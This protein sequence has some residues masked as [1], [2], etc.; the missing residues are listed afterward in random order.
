[1]PSVWEEMRHLQEVQSLQ[2]FSK[3]QSVHTVDDYTSEYSESTDEEFIRK[4]DSSSETST[5]KPVYCEMLVW[6]GQGYTSPVKLQIDCGATVNV[7]PRRHVPETVHVLETT[8][9]L[10]MLNKTA[11]KPLGECVLN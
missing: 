11:V 10:S 5:T 1:V 8:V 7:I 4:V 9:T 2:R 3:E 6:D